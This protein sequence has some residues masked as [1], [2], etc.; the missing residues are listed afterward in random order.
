MPMTVVQWNPVTPERATVIGGRTG[1]HSRPRPEC[2]PHRRALK[3]RSRELLR[4]RFLHQWF[5]TW[6]RARCGSN[7]AKAA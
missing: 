5:A 6:C 4:V 7:S 3:S 1:A 2:G